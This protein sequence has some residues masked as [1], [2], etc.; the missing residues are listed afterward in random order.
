VN[1][2]PAAVADPT[3]T[4]AGPLNCPWPEAT[5]TNV[6]SVRKAFTISPEMVDAF[7]A[8]TG[9]R[10]ALHVDEEIARRFRYRQRVVHGMLPV[11]LMVCLEDAF[12]GKRL[13]F[14]A[15]QV[16][17]RAPVFPGVALRLTAE[18][19]VSENVTVFHARWMGEADRET[20]IEA[21]GV[22]RSDEE[23]R[24]P[25]ISQGGVCLLTED[26]SENAYVIEALEGKSES[27]HFRLDPAV[28][29]RYQT[30]LFRPLLGRN[31]YH[32]CPNLAASLLLS[33]LV[34]M[35]LPGRYA[36]FAS[37]EASFDRNLSQEPPCCL[38]GTVE[39]V[40]TSGESIAISATFM[41]AG[42]RVGSARLK[43]LVN[44]PPRTMLDCK[45]IRERY[46]ETGVRGKV[47][48]ITGSS[49]GIGETAAK[50][51]AMHG[52]KTIVHYYQGKRDAESIVQEIQAAGGTAVGLR[53][54]I[55]DRRQVAHFFADVLDA[56][57]RV[58]ILINNAVK[59]F[60][61]K[62]FLKLD[63]EDYLEEFDVS[64]KGMHNCC[65][66]AIPIF[67]REGRGKI[68]NLSSVSVHNPVTG[69]NKYITAKA[70]VVGY[71]L[72]LAK[73]LLKDNIQV[74]VVVPAM[75]ETDLLSSI[76]SEL[77]RRMAHEREY[78]RNLAPIEVALCMLYLSSSWADGMTGQQVVLNLGEPPYA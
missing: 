22:V 72:S 1:T 19:S 53:C 41:E 73:E 76:P 7:A 69:Q 47:A 17:F 6:T 70:A 71:S 74:N 10:N 33:T 58:D 23:Q 60:R 36:T 18:L 37:F 26:V 31:D 28:L 15:L 29:S 50:L 13:T 64:L 9:D 11:S 68:V 20:M 39:K 40:S 66:E 46:L 44:P 27:V 48:V 34:G 49:R 3:P 5:L 78:G 65:R 67:R 63:W 57:G 77:V 75:T 30:L 25:A 59:E 54:D 56:Y 21:N 12:P 43:V 8:L 2:A 4:L 32:F 61:P 14:T 62:E 38:S 45:T 55:R 52:A 42:E 51:F 35:R 16:R 24:N